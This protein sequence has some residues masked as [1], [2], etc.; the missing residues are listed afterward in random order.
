MPTKKNMTGLYDGSAP[1]FSHGKGKLSNQGLPDPQ[2]A[3]S[4]TG[5]GMSAGKGSGASDMGRGVGGGGSA[6]INKLPGKGP[7]TA[8]GL[9]SAKAKGVP[10]PFGHAD[11]R[12]K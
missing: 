2:G 7:G 5:Q 3:K 8:Q 9:T 10:Q 6:N 11:T 1:S 12:K 4:S